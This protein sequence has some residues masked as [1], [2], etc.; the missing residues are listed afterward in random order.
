MPPDSQPL[1]AAT[2]LSPSKMATN[3]GLKWNPA[4]IPVFSV[5]T[6]ISNFFPF[7]FPPFSSSPY[8]ISTARLDFLR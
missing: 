7:S 3:P 8:L 2:S 5:A 1:V 4:W 6:K